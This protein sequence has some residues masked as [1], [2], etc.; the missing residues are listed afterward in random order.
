MAFLVI[1]LIVVVIAVL[2]IGLGL[3][4]G[5]G[6]Q[7][8]IPALELGTASLMGMIGLIA[9]IYTV[10]RVSSWSDQVLTQ[11]DLEEL[12]K[13]IELIELRDRIQA[14]DLEFANRRRRRKKR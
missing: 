13:E 14:T 2:L 5:W 7:A 1:P 10:T 11:K 9:S 6:L 3:L 12:D 8:L 4:L